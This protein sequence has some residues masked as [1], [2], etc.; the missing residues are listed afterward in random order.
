M[1]RGVDPNPKKKVL[2][3]G[4]FSMMNFMPEQLIYDK[5]RDC[6]VRFRSMFEMPSWEGVEEEEIT[7]VI[8]NPNERV[9]SLARKYWGE[10]RIE[11]YWV[12]SARN[13]L[14][15]PDVQ[16]YMG[17]ELKIPSR[18]WIDTVLLQQSNRDEE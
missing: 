10:E 1:T 16:L 5:D 4:V 7:H 11:L 18:N 17:R 9:D 12:I 15:L 2:N 6:P 14:D 3:A 13:S 8:D